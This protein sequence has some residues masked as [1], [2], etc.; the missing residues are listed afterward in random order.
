MDAP[1]SDLN[2]HFRTTSKCFQGLIFGGFS[3]AGCPS[4]IFPPGVQAGSPGQESTWLLHGASLQSCACFA[5]E[6]FTCEETKGQGGEQL[7]QGDSGSQ[8]QQELFLP[9]LEALA[10]LVPGQWC[11]EPWQDWPQ[12]RWHDAVSGVRG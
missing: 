2:S 5:K 3:N 12:A 10:W 4:P 9:L 6:D 1:V 11:G 8:R 7:A